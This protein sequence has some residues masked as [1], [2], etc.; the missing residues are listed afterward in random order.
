[1]SLLVCSDNGSA[2]IV[3][4]EKKGFVGVL[5]FVVVLFDHNTQKSA[6]QEKKSRWHDRCREFFCRR[7]CIV[8]V[9]MLGHNKQ[10]LLIG[11][12]LLASGACYHFTILGRAGRRFLPLY[13]RYLDR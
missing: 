1:M 12:C 6:Q 13:F 7:T 10:D 2:A 5:I 4:D 3:G 11:S 8:V 9:N